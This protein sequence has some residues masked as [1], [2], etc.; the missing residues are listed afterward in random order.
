MNVLDLY[1]GAGGA[2]AGYAMAWP[3]ARIT[4]VDARPQPNYPFH[5]VQAM[6]AVTWMT[7]RELCESIPPAYT[8]WIAEQFTLWQQSA[9][10]PQP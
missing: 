10:L 6:G 4:G 3:G 2:G 8:Q 1:C 5:F 7:W 9:L